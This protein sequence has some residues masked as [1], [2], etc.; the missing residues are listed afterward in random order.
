M[1]TDNHPLLLI[2][3]A[4]EEQAGH[5]QTLLDSLGYLVMVDP[6][7]EETL[8]AGRPLCGEGRAADLVLL[9]VRGARDLGGPDLLKGLLQACQG[10]PLIR[11]VSGDEDPR[12]LPDEALFQGCLEFT[13]GPAVAH[14]TLNLT[15]E[16]FRDQ[17]RA[18]ALAEEKEAILRALPDPVFVINREGKFLEV[19]AARPEILAV[20]PEALQ[21]IT[22]ADLFDAGEEERILDIIALALASGETQIFEYEIG[23]AGAL[24]CFEAQITRCDAAAE[25]VLA[26]AHDITERREDDQ[27]IKA[28][29]EEKELLLREVHHRIKNNMAIMTGILGLQE[30]ATENP[31]AA[32]ILSDARGRLQSMAVLYEQLYGSPDFR[33]VSARGYLESLV[34]SIG[35]ALPVPPGI[36]LTITADDTV[37]ESRTLAVAGIIANELV[38]NA[39]KHA[40]PR[41]E[42]GRISLRFMAPPDGDSITLQ[43]E[44]DGVGLPPEL[45]PEESSG[46]GFSLVR[47]LADQE[48]ASLEITRTGGTC[49]T[50]T[51]PQ[52]T[53]PGHP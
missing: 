47:L 23:I 25:T 49:L 29:L 38:T 4:R 21:G 5:L 53:T 28:L 52:R 37:V 42:S 34:E 17:Q 32:R 48:K 3:C 43:V 2:L 26:V 44:D 51:F 39:L 31:E 41:K 10:H 30:G 18:L 19:F 6:R 46:F 1:R 24:R 15:R 14:H 12:D 40:F 9:D 22:L 35:E 36:E 13:A 33:R 20:P 45:D 16:L 7:G 11:L 8:A 50:V 27:T